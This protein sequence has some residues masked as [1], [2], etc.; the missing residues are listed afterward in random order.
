MLAA[1]RPRRIVGVR[2]TRRLSHLVAYALLL[3]S[4]DNPLGPDTTEV[5]TVQVQPLTMS[6]AVGASG[7][8]SATI[9]GSQGKSLAGRKVFWSTQNPT[10]ATVSQTG[11]V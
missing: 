9:T 10:V 11:T 5:G 1:V 4:C 7:S 3:V 8:L 2:R 6:I